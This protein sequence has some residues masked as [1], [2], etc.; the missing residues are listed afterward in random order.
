MFSSLTQ[1]LTREKE[2][3]KNEKVLDDNKIYELPEIPKIELYDRLA[4]VL[5]TEGEE[6]LE[7]NILQA[8]ELEDKNIEEIK[9]EHE[10]DKIT[11]A[12]DEGIV[13]P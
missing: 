4:N 6:T 13:P 5:R 12:F 11:H 3:T 8:K 7:D 2:K 9:E 10:F 1:T